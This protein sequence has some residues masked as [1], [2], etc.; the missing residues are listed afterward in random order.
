MHELKAHSENAK[1][2]KSL[3]ATVHSPMPYLHL[4][5]W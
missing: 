3:E 4:G 2:I 5:T 1:S